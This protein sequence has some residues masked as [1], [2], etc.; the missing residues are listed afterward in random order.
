MMVMTSSESKII[1][2]IEMQPYNLFYSFKH[3]QIQSENLTM[4]WAVIEPSLSGFNYT[5]LCQEI[6]LT[7]CFVRKPIE[8]GK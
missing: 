8:K 4:S 5:G 6:S 3:S 7:N 1:G 2:S